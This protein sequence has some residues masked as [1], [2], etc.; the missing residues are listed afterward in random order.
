[1]TWSAGAIMALS[2]C[3]T[4]GLRIHFVQRERTVKFCTSLNERAS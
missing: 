3:Q 1:M 4:V 2:V